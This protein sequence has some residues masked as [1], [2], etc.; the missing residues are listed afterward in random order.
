VLAVAIV[1]LGTY[2]SHRFMRSRAVD[3]DRQ[4]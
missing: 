2:V 4:L 3:L 1:A